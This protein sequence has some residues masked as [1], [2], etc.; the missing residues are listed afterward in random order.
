MNQWDLYIEHSEYA[1]NHSLIKANK[2]ELMQFKQSNQKSYAKFRELMQLIDCTVLDIQTLQYKPRVLIASMM[3]ILLG[4]YFKN[5]TSNQIFEQ[6]PR[7]SFYL[8]DK[9]SEFNDLFGNFLLYSFGFE[10]NDLLPSIQYTSTY[11]RL[12]ISLDLPKAVK[13]TKE[14]VL[15]VFFFFES[16]NILGTF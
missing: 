11:V 3:Y 9:T 8:L 4:K 12:P 6:F 16:F 14:N 1:K 5:F 13:M 2:I 7:N 10:L 15:E